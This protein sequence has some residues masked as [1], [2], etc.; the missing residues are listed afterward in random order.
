MDNRIT[1]FLVTNNK[2]LYILYLMELYVFIDTRSHTMEFHLED[3]KLLDRYPKK[4]Q[5]WEAPGRKGTRAVFS[6][7]PIMNRMQFCFYSLCMLLLTS[8]S[9]TYS[10]SYISFFSSLPSLLLISAPCRCPVLHLDSLRHNVTLSD[11]C[12][13]WRHEH[14]LTLWRKKPVTV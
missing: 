5:V 12:L 7:P 6:Y 9:I 4:F 14:V 11:V 3:R 8:F 1:N 2:R 13:L 10:G